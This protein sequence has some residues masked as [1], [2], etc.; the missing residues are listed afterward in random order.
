MITP[1]QRIDPRSRRGSRIYGRAVLWGYDA[2]VLAF[3]NR[4][5][6]RCRTETMLENYRQLVS[7]RHLDVGVGTGWY[8][9]HTQLTPGTLLTL[10]DLNPQALTSAGERIQQAHPQVHLKRIV[11]NVLE[12]LPVEAESLDSISINYLLHCVPGTWAT[13][14]ESFEHLARV[15]SSHGTLFGATILGRGVQ[16]NLPGRALMALYNRIGVFDNRADDLGGLD[17]ALR[18][19]FHEVQ[20]HLSQTV[21]QFRARRPRRT[22]E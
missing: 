10:M 12:P 22:L 15:L 4:F 5:A 19:H 8:L 3:S 21:V 2:V 7:A 20:I 9:S 11:A 16:H 1:E 6:W 14:G 17:A 18:A 13:K